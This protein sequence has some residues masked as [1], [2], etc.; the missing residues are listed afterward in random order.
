MSHQHQPLATQILQEHGL[1]QTKHRQLLLDII[2]TS[3]QF[4]TADQLYLQMV[5]QDSSISLSTVY[6]IV[7]VFVQKDILK[8]VMMDSSNQAFYELAHVHHCHH[9]ICTNCHQVIHIE[10]CPIH[11]YETNIAN[12]YGFLVQDHKLELYGLCVN[13]QPK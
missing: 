13:C 3:R 8:K 1:S 9:L 6:R 2:A 12:A 10:G 7:D 11:D 4:L 5:E